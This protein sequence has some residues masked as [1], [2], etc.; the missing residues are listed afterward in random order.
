MIRGQR[1]VATANNFAADIS[2]PLADENFLLIHHKVKVLSRK[3]LGVLELQRGPLLVHARLQPGV[4]PKLDIELQPA[5]AR[6]IV[7][8]RI[9][10]HAVE[11]RACRLKRG[12]VAWTHLAIQLDESFLR[13][14]Q[15]IAP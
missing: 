12:R 15:R 13:R 7:L 5:Y 4:V 1:A 11:E 8:T 9:E 6:E 14:L 2:F 10:K 3:I